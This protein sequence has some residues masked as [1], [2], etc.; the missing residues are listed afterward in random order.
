MGKKV[1]EILVEVLE[2]AGVKRCYGIVGDTL[3]L[4]AEHLERS[5]IEWVHVRHEEAGAFAAGSEALLTNNLT[6]CAGS[7]GPGSLHFIN[8]LYEAN[9]NRAPVVLIASQIMTN[10]M[11][12]EFI[13]EVDFKTVYKDCTVYCD[14]ILSPEQA[15]KKAVMAC[16]T[17]LTKQGVAVLIVPVDISH[18]EIKDDFPYRVHHSK[19]VTVPNDEE[20]DEIAKILNAG[21]KIT[22]YAGS[23]CENA[24]DEIKVVAEK[25]GAPIAHTSR[26]KS[27]LEHDNPYNV[28]MTGL[29]GTEAGYKAIL[30]CDT[31]LLL[32]ADFAWRQFY[33]DNA[34]I[35]QI[36]INPTH[37]GRRHHVTFGAVGDIKPTLRAL[38]SRLEQHNDT[39]FQ[40][41]YVEKFT[42]A[43]ASWKSHLVPGHDDTI[44]GSYL[45]SLI[46]R[47]ADEDALISG[48]DGTP[49]VWAVRHTTANGKR[50]IFGSFLH[51]TMATALPNAIG[52]KKAAPD[53]QV[54]AM[55]GDGGLAMLLGELLTVIQEDVP[56]KIAV[57]DNAKLGFVE[58]EQKAEGMLD[59]F[60]RLKNPDFGKVAQAVGLWGKTVSKASEIEAAVQEWLA[61]PGPALLNV[62][63]SPMELVKPP[64]TELKPVLGM[65]LYTTRAILHGRGGEV[66]ELVRENF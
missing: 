23:G 3:N 28:G 65:A 34:K 50:R 60:T 45:T 41:A 43:L 44:P 20:L 12:F 38:M 5:P 6:A 35:V 18:S 37:L 48:D 10:D 15:R 54:I 30:D 22:I 55:C 36:D 14:M 40:Q 17:A 58:I 4:F 19:P 39:S 11:G 33:P 59:T 2:Q 52:L 56:I 62:H 53:R 64:F 24:L 1:A 63:V 57:F 31:L 47:Y 51:G 9:R 16:Q 8:G 61:Q 7:C 46:D 42:K 29:L 26:A 32:G 13:Q 25:L 49:I 66:L 21:K 27:F